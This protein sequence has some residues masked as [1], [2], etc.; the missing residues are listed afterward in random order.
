MSGPLA[1]GRQEANQQPCFLDKIITP[2][3]FADSRPGLLQ[4][5]VSASS[6]LLTLK[7]LDRGH[8]AVA[9]TFGVYRRVELRD[10]RVEA[11]LV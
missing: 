4:P 6:V 8:Q 5:W 1:G 10:P 9:N 2:T 11:T 3:A 7:E